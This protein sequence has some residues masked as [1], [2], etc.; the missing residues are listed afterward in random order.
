MSTNPEAPGPG[1]SADPAAAFAD[2]PVPAPGD[3]PTTGA[4]PTLPR[5]PTAA[6]FAG[7]LVRGV[8]IGVAE[9]VP[10]VSGGTIALVTGI[11]GRLIASAK[12]IIDVPKA[13][14]TRDNWR[15]PFGRADWAMLIPVGI[16]MVIAVFA[17]AGTMESFFTNQPVHAK[18]LFMGMI[19]AS[20]AIPFLEI[21]PGSLQTRKSKISA[22]ALFCVIAVVAFV[23]TSLPRSEIV[24]PPLFLVFVAAAL[25]VCALVMPGVSGSFVLLVIGLYAPTLAAVDDRNLAY[26]GI[27]VLGALVGLVSFVRVLQWLLENHHTMAMVAAAGLLLGSLRALWP[28]QTDTGGALAPDEHIPAAIGLF[29]LGVVIIAG[30]AA[31]Q[32]KLYIAD[33]LTSEV[34]A[35]RPD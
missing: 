13:I 21:K 7:N 25:A 17:I 3:T 33:S 18:A 29:I 11:Y 32:R 22:T 14:I 9:T 10:G 26:I 28:W 5:R 15:V 16:G 31:V 2:S 35:Q 30:V 19:A 4:E 12:H 23:L 1:D 6:D 34:E 24:D 27:F 8:L 20:V